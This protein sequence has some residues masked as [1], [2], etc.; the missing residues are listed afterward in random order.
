MCLELTHQYDDT[1]NFRCEGDFWS[2]VMLQDANLWQ[3]QGYQQDFSNVN[4]TG[5]DCRDTIFSST[6]FTGANLTL[7]NFS[8]ANLMYCDFTGATMDRTDR[9]NASCTAAL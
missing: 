1:K 7:V 2:H 9:L 3:Q 5:A 6:K 4:I 8:E